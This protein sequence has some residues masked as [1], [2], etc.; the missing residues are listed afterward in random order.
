MIGMGPTA[1]KLESPFFVLF[2]PAVNL[3]PALSPP[4]Q[5]NNPLAGLLRNSNMIFPISFTFCSEDKGILEALSL[6]HCSLPRQ[7]PTTQP[8][9]FRPLSITPGNL[10]HP[11]AFPQARGKRSY[12]RLGRPSFFPKTFPR[13]N[14]LSGLPFTL[15][16]FRLLLYSLA[17]FSFFPVV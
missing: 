1:G 5:K 7:R 4:T 12:T 17:L 8:N 14:D 15:Q 6:W 10:P 13:D 16:L 11:H 3:I 9:P 2:S